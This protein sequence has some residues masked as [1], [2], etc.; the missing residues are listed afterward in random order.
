VVE[1]DG[2]CTDGVANFAALC[3]ANIKNPK[4]C[5]EVVGCSGYQACWHQIDGLGVVMGIESNDHA[6][7]FEVENDGDAG[8]KTT[9]L[10]GLPPA[11]CQ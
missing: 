4:G 11:P 7:A 5:Q 1:I 9:E 10:C 8:Y 3:S 2:F 6:F